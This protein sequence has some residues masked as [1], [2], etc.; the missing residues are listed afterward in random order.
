[1]ASLSDDLH[2]RYKSAGQDHLIKFWSTLSETERK[3]LITQL[4]ALDIERVN[5]IYHKAVGAEKDPSDPIEPLPEG[6]SDTAFG[7]SDKEKEWRRTGLDAIARG[8][9]GVLLMAGG[10]GTRLGS[11]APKG[12]YD[13]GLPSHKSLFQ[14]QAERI[15]RLQAV[16]EA[17]AG[18]PTGSVVIPWYIMTSGP[19]R[20]ETESFFTKNKYFGL[21]S[22]NVIFFEQGTLPCLT[23]G[24]KVMLD[25]PSHIAV[26]P[27]GNGGLYA[28]TRSPLSPSNKSHTVL[29]DLAQRKV[30]YVHAYCVDNC[31]VRVADPVFLGYSITKQADCA[32]KVVPKASPKESVGVVA[33]RGNKFSV[34]E[35]SEISPEQAEQRN[36]HG[37]LAFGAANIA[38]HFYTTTFLNSVENFEGELAF[39]VAHKKIP[40]VDMNTGQ[41]VKPTKPNGMK[42]ELFIFDV[43]PY[44]ENFAVLEVA[45][46]EEFSPLKNAPGTGSDDPETSRRDLLAQHKRFLEK[47]GAHVKEGVEI[48]IS[49]LLSYAGEGLE[50][51]KGKTFT[52]SGYVEAVEELDA[53]V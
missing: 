13:I 27:D 48:E 53:L 49:P 46:N 6:A 29:S 39:H 37:E 35:Y 11:S 25:S 17:K 36:A 47:A 14:Y 52:K 7:V 19:T 30:L 44:I 20:R 1:M 38:N 16:A 9:V 3:A 24:G 21:D 15:A 10:Q 33:C 50:A 22:K 4:E 42:L 32:A 31:L 5:R 41:V 43:F 28:A 2:E 8:E 40:S 45:R 34:V 12:C 26:A 23:T 18:K 51:V